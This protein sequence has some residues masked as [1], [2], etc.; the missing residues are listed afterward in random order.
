MGAGE[1][2]VMSA[3]LFVRKICELQRIELDLAK[4]DN[5]PHLLWHW[6]NMGPPS[7]RLT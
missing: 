3:I 7:F 2:V 6:A 4:Q 5:R 1:G